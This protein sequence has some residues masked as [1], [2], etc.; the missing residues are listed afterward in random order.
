MITEIGRMIPAD[1]TVVSGIIVIKF[2]IMS[3]VQYISVP[4]I[5]IA[6]PKMTFFI[7]IP[8][9]FKFDF[10]EYVLTAYLRSIKTIPIVALFQIRQKYTSINI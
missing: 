7:E 9:R 5:K 3:W 10:V 8:P 1:A 6:E 2:I 4:H